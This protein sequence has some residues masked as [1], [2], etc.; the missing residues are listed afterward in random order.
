MAPSGNGAAA[1]AP[2]PTLPP[3]LLGVSTVTLG[4]PLGTLLAVVLDACTGHEL[5][6]ASV[7]CPG[8]VWCVS[9][10]D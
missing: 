4:E 6:R 5:A 1:A 3:L 9:W 10:I 7:H 2:Q 8:L